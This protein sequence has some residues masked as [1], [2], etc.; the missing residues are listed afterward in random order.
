MSP[1]ARI[2]DESC[3]NV[4]VRG[5]STIHS[6]VAKHVF[7]AA[8]DRLVCKSRR[9][10][11]R[12]VEWVQKSAT[13]RLPQYTHTW[14]ATVVCGELQWLAAQLTAMHAIFDLEMA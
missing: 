14:S 1:R 6:C 8:N 13:A 7:E 12:V 4:V 10:R 11:S 2:A 3:V 5:R 9:K